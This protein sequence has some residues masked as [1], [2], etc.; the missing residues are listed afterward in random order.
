MTIIKRMVWV[1]ET[2]LKELDLACKNLYLKSHPE[3]RGLNLSRRFMFKK[4]VEFYL[5]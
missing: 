1:D 2:D 5:K 3:M 4:L